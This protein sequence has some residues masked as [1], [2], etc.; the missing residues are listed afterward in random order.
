MTNFFNIIDQHAF[1]SRHQTVISIDELK[2]TI[3]SLHEDKSLI[4]TNFEIAQRPTLPFEY[5]EP[6]NTLA[7]IEKYTA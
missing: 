4:M 7:T 3:D 1:N 5:Q 2:K 6:V